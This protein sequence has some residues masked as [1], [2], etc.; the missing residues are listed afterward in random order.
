MPSQE[1]GFY[2]LTALLPI[3][4]GPYTSLNCDDIVSEP[5]ASTR[6]YAHH[7]KYYL[8]QLSDSFLEKIDSKSS[9]IQICIYLI[10]QDARILPFVIIDQLFYNGRRRNDSLID[11]FDCSL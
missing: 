9:L 1:A 11:F 7:L 10:T 4:D 5:C 6:S 8:N 3:K 2:Q